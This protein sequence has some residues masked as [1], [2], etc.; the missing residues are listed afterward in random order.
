MTWWTCWNLCN[1]NGGNNENNAHDKYYENE[2][3]YEHDEFLKQKRE[4]LWIVVM[5]MKM[6]NMMRMIIM[7][8]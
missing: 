2:E 3:Q 4:I 5:K 7:K 6:M 1:E 8:K